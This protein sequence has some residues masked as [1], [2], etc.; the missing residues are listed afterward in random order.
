MTDTYTAQIITLD[1]IPAELR[2]D[3][4]TAWT[5]WAG[6]LRRDWKKQCNA[7]LDRINALLDQN[8]NPTLAEIETAMKG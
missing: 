2:H 3:F 1:R 4:K 6:S 8:P 7:A 5:R